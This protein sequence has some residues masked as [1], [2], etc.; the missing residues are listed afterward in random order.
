MNGPF[1]KPEFL[2]LKEVLLKD[3]LKLA[4]WFKFRYY[5]LLEKGDVLH[6]NKNKP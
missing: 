1:G 6:F 5:L 2:S 4:Q 3:R